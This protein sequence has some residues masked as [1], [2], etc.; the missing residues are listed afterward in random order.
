MKNLLI[1]RAISLST[2][3]KDRFANEITEWQPNGIIFVSET[4]VCSCKVCLT[5]LQYFVKHQQWQPRLGMAF[6]LALRFI[7]KAK[8]TDCFF[9]TTTF[10]TSACSDGKK[11]KLNRVQ[12][13]DAFSLVLL[14]SSD[15]FLIQ[16]ITYLYFSKKMALKHDFN[17]C[18][19]NRRTD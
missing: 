3:K 13:I 9:Q 2:Y 19:T 4:Q 15:T 16:T 6:A 18:V 11:N 5:K 12:T 7:C 14:N 17:M 10:S 8:E 1:F